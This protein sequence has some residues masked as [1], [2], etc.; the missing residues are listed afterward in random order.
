MQGEC[1]MKRT[2]LHKCVSSEKS[3]QCHLGRCEG[4]MGGLRM[5]V[6]QVGVARRLWLVGVFYTPSAREWK[7]KMSHPILAL[8]P[9]ISEYVLRCR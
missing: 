3:I 8:C 7:T 4:L 5:R 1:G 9:G 2:R 6:W